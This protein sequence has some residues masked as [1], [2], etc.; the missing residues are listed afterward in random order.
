MVLKIKDWLQNKGEAQF[1]FFGEEWLIQLLHSKLIIRL[2][3]HYEAIGY[4][5]GTTISIIDSNRNMIDL[6]YQI[7]SPNSQEVASGWIEAKNI[8]LIGLL[9]IKLEV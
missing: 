4:V 3:R 7:L 5:N 2:H 1:R 8:K 9:N 6:R